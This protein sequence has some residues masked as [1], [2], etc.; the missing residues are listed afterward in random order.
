MVQRTGAI[1]Q[2]L[3]SQPDASHSQP[4]LDLIARVEGLSADLQKLLALFDEVL[5]QEYSRDH[6]KIPNVSIT[7]P[8][9]RRTCDFC[10][11]DIFHS[12]FSCIPCGA[13]EG[14]SEEPPDLSEGLLICS[15]CYAEGRSCG[16]GK[17]QPVQCGSFVELWNL[18]NSAASTIHEAHELGMI[19]HDEEVK[20]EA[21]VDPSVAIMLFSSFEKILQDE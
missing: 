20:Q 7:S 6:K 17:M 4:D 15:G 1:Q 3:R 16:C 11:A 13:S 2:I 18:R 9:E 5:Q 10:A 12:F 19:D 14:D 21:S 8:N